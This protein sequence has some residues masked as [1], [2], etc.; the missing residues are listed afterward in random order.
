M[1]CEVRFSNLGDVHGMTVTE[2]V[3]A[4]DA[5]PA[6]KSSEKP[7]ISI[8]TPPTILQ[9]RPGRKL[10]HCRATVLLFEA[11]PMGINFGDNADEYDP[12]TSSILPRINR[13]EIRG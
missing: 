4:T 12:E 7:D 11:D 6:I 2:C 5:I 1:D 13:R 9:R 10:P 8:S 3:N